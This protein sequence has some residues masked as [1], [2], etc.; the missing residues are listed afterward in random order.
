MADA[1]VIRIKPYYYIH[2]LDNNSNVTRVEVGPQTFTRQEHEKVLLGPEPMIMIPPRHYCV[3]Q[4]P[5]VRN[6]KRAVVKEGNS[7]VKL[8][9]GDEEIRFEQDPF[10]LYPGEKLVSKVSPLQVVAP[11]TALRTKC[12]RDFTDQDG[13]RRRAGDE[14]LFEGP[15]TYIPRVE[16]QVVEVVQAH[17]IKPNQALKIRARRGTLDRDGKERKAGEE[18]LVRHA[19]A[20]LPGVDEEIAEQLNAYV[21]TEKKAI[22]LR[23]TRTFRDVFKK[24]RKAGEEWLVTFNDA[25]THIPDV[26]EQVVGDVKITSLTNRQYCVV[27]DPWVDGKPRLGQKELRRVN[28]L[29]SCYQEKDWKQEYKILLSLVKKRL[30]CSEQDNLLLIFRERNTKLVIDG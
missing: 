27:L 23:A 24:E 15:G 13:A 11:N 26:Y 2:V 30:F 8:R 29:S 12:I 16:V 19:G 7:Q 3:I 17:I 21:L 22:H 18:W 1:S 6:E 4:N 10:P 28:A 20:Y 25:E 9:H 14:Y 5:V